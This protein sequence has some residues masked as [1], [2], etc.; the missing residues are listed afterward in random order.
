[1]QLHGKGFFSRSDINDNH[2][3][4]WWGYTLG[5]HHQAQSPGNGSLGAEWPTI[6]SV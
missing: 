5:V 4:N 2:S 6:H 1:V 3:G